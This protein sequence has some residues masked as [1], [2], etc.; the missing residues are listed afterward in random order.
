MTIV[1]F[2]VTIAILTLLAEE[3]PAIASRIDTDVCEV[4][5]VVFG[6]SQGQSSNE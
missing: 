2:L 3:W 6:A 4:V 1:A 5:F